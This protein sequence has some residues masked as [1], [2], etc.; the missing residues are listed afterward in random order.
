[1]KDINAQATNGSASGGGSNPARPE[2]LP[3]NFNTV[4]DYVKSNGEARAELTRAQ[5]ELA[6]LRAGQPAKQGSEPEGS[7]SNASQTEAE[8]AASAAVADAGLDVAAWQAEF[9][10]TL[11]VS[12]KGRA[13]IAK[14]LEKQFGP[15][16]RQLVDDFIEGQKIR[17]ENQRNQVFNLAGG[18]QNY[19]N[20]IQWAATNLS[21]AEVASYNNV[22]GSGDFNAMSLA[23]DGLKARYVKAN[24]SDPK[25]LSGNGLASS[26]G[27]F[28]ST[29]QM[30][31]AMK[32]PRYRTDPVYRKSVEQKAMRSNF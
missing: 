9:N 23:V 7:V 20:L 28:E 32:D 18:Q 1:M 31:A 19:T 27:G 8:R 21:A 3:A 5:Q 30:T 10:E 13:E 12:E 4:E 14:G 6:R 11:D 26:A 16:A 24:G 25:L 29:A 2:W 22:M 17:V 15:N